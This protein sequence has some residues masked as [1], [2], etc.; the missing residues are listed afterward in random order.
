MAP[1]RCRTFS[2]SDR[3][4]V[5]TRINEA[6]YLRHMGM[7]PPVKPGKTF[8]L[9]DGAEVPTS[10]AS[11]DVTVTRNDDQILSIQ[12]D[13]EGCGAYCENYAESISFDARTGRTITLEDVLNAYGKTEIPKRMMVERVRQYKERIKHLNQQLKAQ[14]AK[15]KKAATD[16]EDDLELR[17]ELNERCAEEE[18]Q[19]KA[20]KAWYP[21]DYLRFGFS[22]A[23][24][25]VFTSGRCSNHAMRALDDVGDVSLTLSAKALDKMLT[26]Y[27]QSLMME[28]T[29]VPEP[30]TVYQQVLHG[31]I[32]SAAITALLTS[33]AYGP[34]DQSITGVY[35]YNKYRKPIALSGKQVG[36]MISLSEGTDKTQAKTTLKLGRAGLSGQWEGDGKTLPMTLAA[37]IRP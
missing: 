33:S 32:G 22:A 31:K 4:A 8:A 35:Y 36:Q 10:T 11:Q 23:K 14:R 17:V 16:T 18:L 9:S 2:Q 15:G 7:P 19:K 27:G 37:E 20:S 29:E 26:P 24:D 1:Y 6:L 21:V 13:R 12:I 34:S 28:A 25:M 5:A 3:L 30:S